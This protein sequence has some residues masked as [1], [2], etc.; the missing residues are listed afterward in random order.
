MHEVLAVARQMRNTHHTGRV[1]GIGER[2]AVQRSWI[3]NLDA[4][5]PEVVYSSIRTRTRVAA[6]IGDGP[7]RWA[8]RTGRRMADQILLAV[9]DPDSHRDLE[10]V[11]TLRRAT[12]ASTLDTLAALVTG[13]TSLLA[14]S[15]EPK[16]N[17]A[18]YVSRE[19][20]L[21]EVT[22]MVHIG[23]EFLAHELLAVIE[24]VLPAADRFRAAQEASRDVAAAWSWLVHTV[25]ELYL[26]ELQAWRQSRIGRQHAVIARLLERRPIDPASAREVLGYD[27]AL[28][29]RSVILWLAHTDLDSARA[30][31]FER[32]AEMLRERSFPKADGLLMR[33]GQGSAELWFSGRCADDIP[34]L[35]QEEW[36]PAALRAAQGAAMQGIEGIRSTYEQ[37]KDAQRL[38]G[39]DSDTAE[40]SS[41]LVSYEGNELISMLLCSPE[42]ARELVQRCLGPLAVDG[43]REQELRETLRVSLDSHGSVSLTATA[44]HTH[45]NT[46]SYRLNQIE[47]L[48]PDA[49]SR[50]EIRSALELAERF[51]K[52]M[53]RHGD[54]D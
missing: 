42:R 53:L 36:W 20:P 24:E 35:T 28:M 11:E 1:V 31:N 26:Q 5:A 12:E 48:L 44:L 6:L 39:L 29:H 15:A 51:P 23:Q 10:E 9:T 41:R 46:V 47:A 52:L 25:S 33:L 2:G 7:T 8:I 27:T 22:R 45:R 54:S 32:M 18:L 14:S 13:D 49:G 38:A 16:D 43:I 3:L 50:L 21:H 34:P 19:L 37:A 4:E 30:F 17:V 40:G